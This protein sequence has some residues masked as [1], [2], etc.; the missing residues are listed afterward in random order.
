VSHFCERQDNYTK[1]WAL[2]EFHKHFLIDLVRLKP[3]KIDVLRNG[4]DPE[5]FREKPTSKNPVKVI[6]SSS[7]DRGWEPAIEICRL[8]RQK[9]PNLE[10]HL[11]YSTSNMR[12][13][14]LEAEANR[15]DRMASSEPWIHSHGM[16]DKKTLIAHFKDAAVWL[17]PT[18][19]LETF[20][21]TALEALCS[22]TYPLVRAIGALPYTLGDAEAAGMCK[23]MDRDAL[24]P[25]DYEIWANELVS[26]I[27]EERWRLVNV[28]PDQYSWE[29]VTKD[30]IKAMNL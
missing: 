3:E 26:S 16:V 13:A 14:G 5:L 28:D 1:L 11:F 27:M 18:D 23:L 2:S 7:P 19:F 24:C 6:F 10:L 17:Y 8:A 29:N 30:F 25:E 20:C 21:I 9:I 15:Y 22:G 12:K 4:I